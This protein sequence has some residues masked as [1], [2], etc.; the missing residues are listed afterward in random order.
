MSFLGISQGM[1]RQY[2][3]HG[4]STITGWWF[5]TMELYDF[6]NSW[7]D[8]PIWLSYFSGGWNHQLD[9]NIIAEKDRFNIS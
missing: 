9:Q 5:G 1:P 6:P 2:S 3:Y 7:D 4:F 8:D